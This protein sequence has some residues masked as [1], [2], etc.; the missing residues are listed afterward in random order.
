MLNP[1]NITEI[2]WWNLDMELSDSLDIVVDSV[3]ARSFD[4]E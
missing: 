2:W 4:A 1:S 3:G